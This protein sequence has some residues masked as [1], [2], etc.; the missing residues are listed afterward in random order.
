MADDL[1]ARL[2]SEISY[3]KISV[4][5]SMEGRDSFGIKR[6][7]LNTF[8]VGKKD[9]GG[10][11]AKEATIVKTIVSKKLVSETYRDA[12]SR[13]VI[14]NDLFKEQA[15]EI[16]RGLTQRLEKLTEAKVEDHEG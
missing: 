11:D 5:F 4:T 14:S 3:E 9:G 16:L 13:G 1:L 10:W 8:T 7:C 15:P 6:F 12:V 2:E